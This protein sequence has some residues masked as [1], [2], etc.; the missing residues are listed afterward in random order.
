MQGKATE[1]VSLE[2]KQTDSEQE[3]ARMR[4]RMSTSEG[5]RECVREHDEERKEERR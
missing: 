2:E 1:N 4:W 3:G 5:I